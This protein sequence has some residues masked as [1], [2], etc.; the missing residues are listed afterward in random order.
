M[1]SILHYNTVY[2]IMA[3]YN[4]LYYSTVYYCPEQYIE[5]LQSALQYSKFTVHYIMT[6]IVEYSIVQYT[7]VQFGTL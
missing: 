6:C 1:D 4:T 5:L 3:E 7:V 2:Y